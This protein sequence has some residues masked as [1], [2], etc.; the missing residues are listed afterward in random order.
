[1]KA[2]RANLQR[3]AGT[4]DPASDQIATRRLALLSQGAALLWA[5]WIAVITAGFLGPFIEK[6]RAV[7]HR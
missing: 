6:V 7:L 5:V 3:T 1:M 4:V 2:S